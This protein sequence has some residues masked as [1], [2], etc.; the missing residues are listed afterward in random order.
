MS[1]P[2]TPDATCPTIVFA[3]SDMVEL[4]EKEVDEVIEALLGHMRALVSDLSAVWDFSP[5]E[6][7]MGRLE[8]LMGRPIA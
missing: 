1:H 5:T 8:T 3:E 4:Y 6:E 7:G 2:E